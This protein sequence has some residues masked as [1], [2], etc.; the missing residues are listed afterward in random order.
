MAEDSTID[1]ILKP[2]SRG[3]DTSIEFRGGSRNPPRTGN[4]FVRVRNR[5]R[6]GSQYRAERR[7]FLWLPLIFVC[8]YG[9]I[10]G[11]MV[12]I[13]YNSD[14]F[15]RQKQAEIPKLSIERPDILDRNGALLATDQIVHSIGVRTRYLIDKAEAV[16][17]ITEVLSDVDPV[18]LMIDL[19]SKKPF[20]PIKRKARK[21]E[22]DSLFRLGIAGMEYQP[23]HSRVYPNGHLAS[24]ILG[25]VDIDN[26]A[27]SGFEKYIDNKGL[28]EAQELGLQV[29]NSDIKP[30]E[31]SIDL[32]LQH[33]MRDEMLKGLNKFHAIAAAGMIYDV[34]TGEVLSLVSL[35]DYDSNQ[36]VE[37]IKP[38]NL[39]RILVGTYEMGSTMKAL[40]TALALDSGK[41]SIND[42]FETKGGEIEVQG[43]TIREYHGTGRKL[44][45]PEV[46]IHSSNIG[47]VKMAL[48][49]G[50]KAQQ[51]FLKK[52]GILDRVITEVPESAAPTPP[53]PWNDLATATVSFGHGIAVTPIAAVKAVGALVNGGHLVNPTFL[54]QEDMSAYDKAPIVIKPETSE[55]IRYVMRLNA[56]TGTA[57]SADIQGYFVG[58]KTGTA[59][60][61][62]NGVYSE[63]KILT[64]FMAV[65]PADKPRF[66]Y[67][68]ILDEPKGIPET[69]NV[70]T[71]SV[72]SGAI[73]GKTIERTAPILMPPRFK[74]PEHPF[75]IM[76]SL[77]AWGTDQIKT[78]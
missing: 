57:K 48:T 51:D 26:H 21:D 3:M 31:L 71:A 43:E 50:T 47:S 39:N 73:C 62:E 67:L 15:N 9:G 1:M 65:F 66:L 75:P 13:G 74:Y 41:V 24:H 18:K 59:N 29:S 22:W 45:V 69:N 32:K 46:F 25:A 27:T 6:R 37:A 49:V 60:K 61:V 8:V 40:N 10:A 28:I 42:A 36:P 30:F 54:K 34:M 33:A 63:T 68:C 58:G 78:K 7:L 70:A 20:V 23:E 35:P 44:T 77:Q 11:R 14:D 17:E 12:Y 53:K 76:E 4:W 55:A 5:L 19:T 52:M 38:E 72:N 2:L 16:N 64:T 56:V